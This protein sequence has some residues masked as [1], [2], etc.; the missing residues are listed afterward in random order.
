MA[1]RGTRQLDFGVIDRLRLGW[2]LLRDPRIPALP[3]LLP[4]ALAALYFL[5]PIDAIPDFLLGFGQL[6]DAGLIA[7][8]VAAIGMLTK[9]SPPEIVAEH[10]ADLG[11]VDQ[12]DQRPPVARPGASARRPARGGAR[13]RRASRSRR[14]TGLMTGGEQRG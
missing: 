7:L 10:A 5:S 11:I 4:P 3:K 6:D 8:A 13:A 9:W 14:N 2:R 1:R 12:P